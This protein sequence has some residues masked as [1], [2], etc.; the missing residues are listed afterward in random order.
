MRDAY[1]I[2]PPPNKERIS[3]GVDDS[4]SFTLS[5]N[6]VVNSPYS[7]IV[8]GIANALN[9]EAIIPRKTRSS[10]DVFANLYSL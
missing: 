9:M 3:V 7:T 6:I 8:S 5:I 1:N 10:S 2:R 4:T